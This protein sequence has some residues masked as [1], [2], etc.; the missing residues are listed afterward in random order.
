[1]ATVEVYLRYCSHY[2]RHFVYALILVQLTYHF[3]P[4]PIL[5]CLLRPISAYCVNWL[6]IHTRC[7]S[8]SRQRSY[9]RRVPLDDP[10]RQNYFRYWVAVAIRFT[11]FVVCFLTRTAG[12]GVLQASHYLV[13]NSLF[14]TSRACFGVGKGRGRGGERGGRLCFHD[15]CVQ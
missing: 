4:H 10:R 14:G 6:F 1:M 5:S 9:L 12:A 8:L 2:H 15:N 11:C 3:Q 7:F 13:W